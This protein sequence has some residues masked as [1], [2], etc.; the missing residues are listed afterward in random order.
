VAASDKFCEDLGDVCDLG[1]APVYTSTE[2]LTGHCSVTFGLYRRA[3]AVAVAEQLL[4]CSFSKFALV[5]YIGLLISFTY[6]FVVTKRI[7]MQMTLQC[8]GLRVLRRMFGPK[9]EEVAGGWRRLHNEELDNLFASPII[10]RVIKSRRM[11]WAKNVARMGE[12]R[13]VYKI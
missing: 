6:E 12:M 4:T 13:I 3:P 7:A 1:S 8:I 9:R 11:R 2:L 10:T 5:E